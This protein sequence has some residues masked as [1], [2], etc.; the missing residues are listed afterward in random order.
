MSRLDPSQ[1]EI[2]HLLFSLPEAAGY[3]LAGGSALL[4][5]G[6]IERPTRD[7]DAFVEAQPSQ[8]PGDVTPLT[9]ALTT[10]LETE[11]WTIEAIRTHQTFAR[12]IATRIHDAVGRRELAV[13]SPRLFPTTTVDGIPMLDPKDL[14]ARKILAMLDRAEG[15]D[16]TDLE[17]L[18]KQHSRVDIITWAQQLD[19]GIT[20]AAIAQAFNQISRLDDSELPTTDTQRTRQLFTTWAAELDS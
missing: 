6:T 12:L 20:H 2:A 17:A 9:G 8:P 11:G 13:D 1:T 7:L 5:S 19:A 3:A 18:Q 4:A 10:K 14:A 16:Y 15:R